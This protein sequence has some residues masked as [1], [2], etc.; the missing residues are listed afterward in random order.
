MQ[1]GNEAD[2]DNGIRERLRTLLERYPQAEIARRCGTTPS[3]ISRYLRDTKIP[4]E[5]CAAAV[6]GLGINPVWLLS[7]EG[8]PLLSDVSAGTA[9][10]GAG[11]LQ[12]VEAMNAVA[13][14]RLGALAGKQHAQ[15]LRELNDALVIYEKLKQQL[16]SHSRP[17]FKELINGLSSAAEASD[18]KRYDQHVAALDQISRLSEDNDLKMEFMSMKAYSELIRG[19]A[20]KASEVQR[21]VFA[22]MLANN[23][24]F[25]I[26]TFDHAKRLGMTLEW[27][28]R[29]EDAIGIWKAAIA[30]AGRDGRRWLT[31]AM[32]RFMMGAS[33]VRLGKLRKGLAIMQ[34]IWPKIP[35]E[36]QN[37]LCH[38]LAY[39]MLL[40]GTLG[41]DAAIQMS[42]PS[43]LAR[44]TL[45]VFALWL[46]DP[47][48]MRNVATMET[49]VKSI[50]PEEERLW[51][52]YLSSLADG[53]NGGSF[54]KA[55]TTMQ[56][57][58]LSESG[59][60]QRKSH[61]FAKQVY[62]AQLE[63][64]A[65]EHDAA[66]K[67]VLENEQT[68]RNLPRALRL[69]NLVRG[70]HYRTALKLAD[71]KEL[72][73]VQGAVCAAARKYF[74]RGF[75]KGFGC[76]REFVDGAIAARAGL[77]AAYK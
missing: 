16:S 7:G 71:G 37:Q 8:A 36:R 27:L 60:D 39:D 43:H 2:L 31:Y 15:T 28:G 63:R 21:Q 12:L 9:Q 51:K 13:R 47:R 70:I 22:A 34:R 73:G 64:L 59:P 67:L 65:G 53:I 19:N 18:W 30:L 52:E 42:R 54:T 24:R 20:I 57:W 55:R 49:D 23:T 62:L 1:T 41:M 50:A 17:T 66:W 75:K 61:Q 45:G 76:Y 26:A 35:P 40:A 3:N 10:M 11:V 46:E 77:D 38:V 48:A 74:A 33:T 6:N 29:S 72:A 5:L 14:I 56:E 58:P 32:T 4:A 69:E 68:I 25:N 44:E